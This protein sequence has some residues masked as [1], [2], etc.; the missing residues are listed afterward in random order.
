MPLVFSLTV[1]SHAVDESEQQS[2]RFSSRSSVTATLS[3]ESALEI[4][5]MYSK[6]VSL[7]HLHRTKYYSL[8]RLYCSRESAM[9][10]IP[11]ER[12]ACGNETRSSYTPSDKTEAKLPTVA[13]N[14]AS[15][16]SLP[17][18]RGCQACPRLK[19]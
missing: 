18:Q 17:N 12:R 1:T 8:F 19:P 11:A 14:L 9:T 3:D 6:K 10:E 4:Y 15:I 16:N 5:S 2:S 7:L 13:A